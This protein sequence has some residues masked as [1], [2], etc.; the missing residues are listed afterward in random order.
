MKQEARHGHMLPI[1]EE[2]R[3]PGTGEVRKADVGDG[4]WDYIYEPDAKELLDSVLR[5][6]VEALVFQMVNENMASEQS[7]RMVA[8]RAASDNAGDD[9]RRIAAHLQ[10]DP[11]GRDHQGTGRDRRRG[12]GHVKID[13]Q[14]SDNRS[15]EFELKQRNRGCEH[16][17]RNHRPVHR[18]GRRRGVR[19]QRD[20]EDLRRPQDGRDRADARGAAA[21]GRRHRAH[22]R[23]RQ[24]RRP[25]PRH[26]RR[27]HRQSDHGAGRQRRR[28]AASWTCSVARSTSAARSTPTSRCRS[29]A[30]RRRSRSSRRRRSCS[31]PASRSSTSSA[32][33]PRAARSACS[34]APASARP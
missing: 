28:S 8:M 13:S 24:L 7:A 19:A 27:Q 4:S 9:H 15:C 23:A 26:D 21:A 14:V 11:P 16:E 22:D 30:T 34:A 3:A 1:P 6:Y 17:S 5:R 29:T 12:G 10:Q 20:A 31:K 2:F 18:R 33:S 32:R 25:A